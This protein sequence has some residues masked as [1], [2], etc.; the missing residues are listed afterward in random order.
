[1]ELEVI[2]FIKKSMFILKKQSKNQISNQIYVKSYKKVK[3][4]H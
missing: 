2:L 4:T 3:Q 1:M